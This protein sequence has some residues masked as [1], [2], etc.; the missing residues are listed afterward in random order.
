MN[1]LW[2]FTASLNIYFL[3]DDGGP[4]VSSGSISYALTLCSQ[5]CSGSP[6]TLAYHGLRKQ[7]INSYKCSCLTR[8][9]SKIIS[10]YDSTQSGN[11]DA[12][13]FRYCPSNYL[14]TDVATLSSNAPFMNYLKVSKAELKTLFTNVSADLTNNMV[15]ICNTT[16]VVNLVTIYMAALLGSPVDINN[17]INNFVYDSTIS[18]KY[19]YYNSVPF[20]I[21][22]PSSLPGYPGL[23]Q[24][25]WTIA[26]QYTISNEWYLRGNK[27]YY[28]CSDQEKKLPQKPHLYLKIVYLKN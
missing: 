9:V 6:Q 23:E 19:P 28:W 14:S 18:Y 5:Q 22:P 7:G 8:D 10:S 26:R 25:Y 17:I 24:A 1:F 12:L 3:S 21:Y 16:R 4:T 11:G 20:A 13:T 2:K 15:N 27:D